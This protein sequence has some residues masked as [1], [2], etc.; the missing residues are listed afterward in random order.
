MRPGRRC[1]TCRSSAAGK[2]GAAQKAGFLPG[3][4]RPGDQRLPR[5]GAL[6]C[7]DL[8]QPSPWELPR[9]SGAE[10]AG[11]TAVR[12]SALVSIPVTSAVFIHHE[13]PQMS[14]LAPHFTGESQ[15]LGLDPFTEYL[16][17]LSCGQWSWGVQSS[18][19]AV[20]WGRGGGRERG[21]LA[22][23]PTAQG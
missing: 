9:A 18:H 3:G 10:P 12:S 13:G 19:V 17:G 6:P 20:F 5:R 16:W 22:I 14:G 4:N 21:A 11:V 2:G 23:R 15:N 1:H 8:K 7:S